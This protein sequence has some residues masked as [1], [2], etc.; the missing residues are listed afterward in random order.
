MNRVTEDG[1]DGQLDRAW[2]DAAAFLWLFS[3]S[4]SVRLSAL[5]PGAASWDEVRH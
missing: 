2:S 3:D 5:A 4:G 1:K